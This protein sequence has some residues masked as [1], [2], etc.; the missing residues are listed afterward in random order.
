M[1]NGENKLVAGLKS[2]KLKHNVLH[3]GYVFRN[4]D[5]I[6][7]IKCVIKSRICK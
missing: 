3:L 6:S 2:S 4:A 7:F 5:E 1:V